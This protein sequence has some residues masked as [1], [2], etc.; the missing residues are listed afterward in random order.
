MS[1][2]E[3]RPKF[4]VDAN[5]GK[6]ARW[7]RMLGYDTIFASDIDDGELVDIGLK[8]GRV[9]LTKDT[10]LMLRRAVASG[11]VKAL[12]TTEDDPKKQM[13]MVI[14]E[15]KLDRE[16]EFTLCLECN[17]PLAP[18]SKDEVRDLVPPYV[19]KTQSQYYQCPG[20]G[21]IYWRGTHWEHMSKV[22]GILMEDEA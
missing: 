1:S 15:M 11:K 21:R 6:L 9:L 8:E 17:V 19:F 16:R 10:Q 12:L 22:L 7:L 2:N 20:C 4:I 13:R 3:P 14:A 5:V 18:R